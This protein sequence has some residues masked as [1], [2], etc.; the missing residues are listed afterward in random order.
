[1]RGRSLSEADVRKR[2]RRLP[3]RSLPA[4]ALIGSL[5]MCLLFC[6]VSR[7]LRRAMG[8][9]FFVRGFLYEALPLCGCPCAQ[10]SSLQM[11]YAVKSCLSLLS[12]VRSHVCAVTLLLTSGAVRGLQGT[13]GD[14]P[15][16]LGLLLEPE[17]VSGAR[18]SNFL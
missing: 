6:A 7:A 10:H 1:M 13:G 14:H 3:L 8:A 16:E 15:A 4:V 17:R 9:R 5:C 11:S 12:S 18:P 2:G